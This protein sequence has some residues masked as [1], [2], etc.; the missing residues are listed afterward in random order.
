LLADLDD[1]LASAAWNDAV[2]RLSSITLV[3]RRGAV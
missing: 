1:G 3:T 2:S